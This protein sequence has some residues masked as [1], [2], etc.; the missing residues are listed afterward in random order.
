VGQHT[1]KI[2]LIISDTVLSFSREINDFTFSKRIYGDF[3]YQLTTSNQNRTD[4]EKLDYSFKI[5][6]DGY[7]NI[8]VTQVLDSLNPNIAYYSGEAT[9][10]YGLRRVDLVYYERGKEKEQKSITISRPNNGFDQFYYTYPS[11]LQIEA[12]KNYDYYF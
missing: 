4:Y 7:P 11:G 10:D 2:N 8:K 3:P 1:Q 6:K 9:D 12:G 5:I